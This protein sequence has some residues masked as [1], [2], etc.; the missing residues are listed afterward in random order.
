MDTDLVKAIAR[1]LRYRPL[2]HLNG[3]AVEVVELDRVE[4]AVRLALG[5]E[6]PGGCRLAGPEPHFLVG[7][8]A[9]EAVLRLERELAAAK[10]EEHAIPLDFPVQWDAGAPLPHLLRNDYRCFLT[11]YVREDDPD[12]DGTYVH[13]KDPGSPDVESL[14]LVE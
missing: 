10:G 14:A 9:K 6:L 13:V 1:G 4:D 11:F 3:R 8:V 5:P 7:E 2:G 12:W